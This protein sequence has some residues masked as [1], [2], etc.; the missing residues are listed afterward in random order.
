MPPT[1]LHFDRPNLSRRRFLQGTAA[2]LSGL[3]LS[4]CGW[5]LADVRTTVKTAAD[6]LYIYT[7]AGYTDRDL[8]DRFTAETGIRAI[9]DVFSSNE[10]MLA[11]LQAGAGGAYSI[12]YP[13]DY[14]VIKM[15][16]RNLLTELDRSKIVGLD[17]LYDRF[18][19]PEYDPGD[20]YSVPLSWGTTGLIYN[21]KVLDPPPK[22]WDYLWENQEALY[23]RM[24]LLNDP[25]ETIGAVLR[26]LG[27]SYNTKD[28]KAIE[29][30]Y[31]KLLELKPAIAS[32]DSDAWRSR[33]IT[34]DLTVAMCY[35][36]DANEVIP[37]NEDLRYVLPKS[38]S[39]LWM[40]T[41][42]IPAS[43]PNPDAAYAWINFMLQPEVAAEICQRLSFATPNEAAF[44]LLPS[45]VQNNVT[46]FPPNPALQN[47]ESLIPLG[48]NV[49][50]IYDRYW[51]R[52]T[53]G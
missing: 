20:R 39:S 41:L 19:N 17:R 40:D 5:T 48:E 4:G 9:A 51:T 34:G 21:S 30:A 18:Q 43:A 42:V 33:I 1:Q 22:D 13:S 44:E 23:K 25:R 31:E 24:T 46:L 52:L 15:R 3:A 53:S 38:G 45:E 37:E 29:R 27:Y 16:D 36:S 49:T 12:I 28:P 47:S 11:K 8:L 7:W 35:S 14:M 10:E 6:V 26:M 2:V 50:S 32:F